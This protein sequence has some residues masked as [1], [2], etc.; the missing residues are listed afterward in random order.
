M[1]NV[2]WLTTL[3][4]CRVVSPG[5]IALV[6]PYPISTVKHSVLH[7]RELFREQGVSRGF[8]DFFLLLSLSL[9]WEISCQIRVKDPSFVHGARCPPLL[10]N[11]ELSC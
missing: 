3:L 10:S 1:N 5:S 4:A 7:F 2:F 9:R 6:L 11:D 8:G